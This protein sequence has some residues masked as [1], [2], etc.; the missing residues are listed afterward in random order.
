VPEKRYTRKMTYNERIFI[1]ADEICP[2]V[3]T[4]FF[5]NG[6]GFF[7]INKWRDA[8]EKASAVN[9]GSRLILKGHL[10]SSRWIDSGIT[11]PVIEIDG[12]DWDGRGP[13][14][15]PFLQ[16]RLIPR[17][18]PTCEVLLIRGNPLYACFRTHHGVMDGRGTLTWIEDI[19]RA[20][21]GEKLIGALSTISD[22]ELARAHQKKYRVPFPRDNIAPTGKTSGYKTGVTWKR[23]TKPGSYR[24]ILGQVCI[25]L[26]QEAWKHGNGSVR[27]S[28]P[29]DIRHLQKGLRSTGNLSIAIYIEVKPDSTP[30]SVSLDIKK[31]LEEKRDCMIDRFDP[32]IRYFPMK[33]L[34]STGKSWVENMYKKEQYG[35]SGILSNMGKIPLNVFSGGGFNA[36]SFWGIPP[37]ILST[38]Y[39]MGIAVLENSLELIVTL[40]EV[41]ATDNRLDNIL[42]SIDRGLVPS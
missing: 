7:D 23:I 29:S 13:D 26:A 1:A 39:F 21:R 31:Q 6:D 19:F 27:F 2:P 32:I 41:L 20:L 11:P 33:I 42:D 10:G 18:G 36:V 35:T 24:N 40:P 28:I 34:T 5:F 14:G 3:V 12:K 16:K 25:L 38:P 17:K 37:S 9:P 22:I 8:V 15:A 30:E 4:Q